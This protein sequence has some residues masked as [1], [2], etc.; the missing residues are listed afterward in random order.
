MRRRVSDPY[1]PVVRRAAL[2]RQRATVVRR[3]GVAIALFAVDGVVHALEDQCLRC[4]GSLGAGAQV[5][6][7]A[8]C[9]GCGWVYDLATGAVEGVPGLRTERFEV[10]I[11][12]PDVR[13]ALPWR[14][15][16]SD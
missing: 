12:G 13:I 4:S 3:D 6:G 11:D 16:E 1:V 14:S 8:I 2:E 15:G 7:L 10:R 9:A 5:R